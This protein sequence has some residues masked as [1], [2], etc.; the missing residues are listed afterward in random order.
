MQTHLENIF[1][2]E[3]CKLYDKAFDAYQKIYNA[4][5]PDFQVWKHY[6]FFLWN[7]IEEATDEFKSH[8]NLNQLLQDSL[9]VGQ[10]NFSDNPDF[11][12]IAGYTISIFPYEYGDYYEM[13]NLGVEMLYKATQLEPNNSIY[14][15]VYLGADVN[16]GKTPAY[17]QSII[18]AAPKVLEN[19]SGKGCLNKY[20]KQI[21]YRIK[22][23]K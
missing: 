16:T 1:E 6:Y 19:Y 22:Y 17:E 9:K 14:I 11:N 21:L 23:I 7:L 18:E 3:D 4:E 5:K 13:K 15:M 10:Q 2:L 8:H 20:F 12:F